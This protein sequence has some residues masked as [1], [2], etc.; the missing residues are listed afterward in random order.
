MDLFLACCLPFDRVD[1]LIRIYLISLK[2]HN[3]KFSKDTECATLRE[4][5]GAVR[6]Q[7]T[8]LAMEVSESH[9]RCMIH[10]HVRTE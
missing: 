5:V 7:Y 6:C 8:N 4:G 3:V 10:K 9:G 1:L 2:H